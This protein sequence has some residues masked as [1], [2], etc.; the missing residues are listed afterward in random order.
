MSA[1]A[2]LLPPHPTLTRY[3]DDPAVKRGFL[4][5]IFDDTAP[6]YDRVESILSLGS[7]RWYRRKALLRAG[8]SPGMRVLD[9]A[10]GTGLVAREEIGITGCASNIVG[11]DPSIGMMQRAV[12]SL[13]IAAVLGVGEQLPLPPAQFDFVSMGYA[14]RHVADVNRAFAEF[15]R[16][17]KP[18]GRLCILEITPP[19]HW[20]GRML[21]RAYMRGLVPL[22]TRLTTGRAN[23]QVLWQYYWDTIE[24]CLTPDQV[25][26]SLSNIGF[27]EVKRHTELGIFSEF[28]AQKTV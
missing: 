1:E 3:Y 16:V 2:I 27:S 15:Y 25:M 21:L 4:K 6:D 17:L 5:Q 19:P 28:T 24:A 26:S 8:L 12:D 13:G 11:V 14:L 9:V 18:G 20:P 7:G 23:S 10:V 22:L